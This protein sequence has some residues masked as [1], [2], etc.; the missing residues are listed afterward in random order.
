MLLPPRN[1]AAELSFPIPASAAVSEKPSEIEC[2]VISLF[3]QLEMTQAESDWLDAMA[4]PESPATSVRRPPSKPNRTAR[5]VF[6]GKDLYRG[7]HGGWQ[8]PA[9]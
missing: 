9:A 4:P 3:D 2:A 1:F 5:Q 8:G 7:E 6:S